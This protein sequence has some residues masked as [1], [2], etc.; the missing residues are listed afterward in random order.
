MTLNEMLMSSDVTEHVCGNRY[1]WVHD[2][3]QYY[4]EVN[5]RN[6]CIQ[7]TNGLIFRECYRSTPIE[8]VYAEFSL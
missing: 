5:P 6:G 7:V 2:G 1:K 4:A 8:K 3:I